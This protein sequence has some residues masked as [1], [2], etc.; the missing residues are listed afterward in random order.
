[1]SSCEKVENFFEISEIVGHKKYDAL[2][3][4][5]LFVTIKYSLTA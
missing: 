5:I 1:M 2:S 3:Y 4:V